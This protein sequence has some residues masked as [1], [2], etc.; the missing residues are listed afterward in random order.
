M[1]NK[2]ELDLYELLGEIED[3]RRPEGRMHE[4]RFILVLVI[5]SVMSGFPSLRSMPDFIQKNR[6]A[7]KETFHPKYGRFPS[8]QTIGRA[9]QGADF[10]VFSD[11]FFRWAQSRVPMTKK[12]WISADGKTI[13]GTGENVRNGFQNFVSVITL[14]GNKQKQ[15]LLSQKIHTKK[16]NEIPKIQE[17]LKT[18]SLKKMYP[19]A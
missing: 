13:R 12:E 6:Q 9:L 19:H 5:L 1:K 11:I 4:L 15:P 2:K 7:L 16:E 8:R 10:D 3:F 14:F 18:L 17:I